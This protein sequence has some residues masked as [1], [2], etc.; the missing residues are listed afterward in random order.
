MVWN[1]WCE[2]GDK[3]EL[4]CKHVEKLISISR[5]KYWWAFLTPTQRTSTPTLKLF[6]EFF[7]VFICRTAWPTWQTGKERKERRPRWIGTT[8][9]LDKFPF[10]LEFLILC[11]T[12]THLVDLVNLF[13]LFW[14][15]PIRCV[16]VIVFVKLPPPQQFICKTCLLKL[17]FPPL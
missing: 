5:W 2:C 4:W 1:G 8:G 6:N 16:I 7:I 10:L 9:K 17:S 13:S 14:K 12:K 11:V 3:S 15:F